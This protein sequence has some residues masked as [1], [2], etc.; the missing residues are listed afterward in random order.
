MS[1][2]TIWVNGLPAVTANFANRA[3]I[4][5][6]LLTTSGSSGV[7]G[8]V[9]IGAAVV[10]V[11]ASDVVVVVGVVVDACVIVVSTSRIVVGIVVT[12]S[13]DCDAVATGGICLHQI[14]K[15][16]FEEKKNCFCFK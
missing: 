6:M 11:V 9:T 4:T 10:V 12:C 1:S 7:V 8:S 2:G 13:D 14:G 5:G 16:F 15:E 3:L